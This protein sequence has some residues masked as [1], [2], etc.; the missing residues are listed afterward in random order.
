MLSMPGSI[1]I[2]AAAAC[3]L[4]GVKPPTLYAYVSR[5]LVRAEADAGDARRSLY[6][7]ADVEALARRSRRHV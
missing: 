2:D 3:A 1:P 6:A 4:L 5:R 7:R